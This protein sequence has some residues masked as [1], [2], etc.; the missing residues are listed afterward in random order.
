MSNKPSASQED[1]LGLK[2]G[3]AYYQVGKEYQDE[4][5]EEPS[6]DSTLTLHEKR[7]VLSRVNEPSR[8]DRGSQMAMTGAEKTD[9]FWVYRS[10]VDGKENQPTELNEVLRS[11]M[12]QEISL[13]YPY[14]L[15]RL[16]HILPAKSHELSSYTDLTNPDGNSRAQVLGNELQGLSRNLKREHIRS[17]NNVILPSLYLKSSVIT[18]EDEYK[19]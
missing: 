3:T 15:A 13:P 4:L 18:P 1:T 11:R 17:H 14:N 8:V 5:E 7:T 6:L 9:S 10:T 16:A 12:L 19:D 2:A